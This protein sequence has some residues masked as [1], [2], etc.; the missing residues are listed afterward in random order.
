MMKKIFAF[1]L[2]LSINASMLLVIPSFAEDAYTDTSGW[3]IT[4]ESIMGA[5]NDITK[6]IDGDINTYWHSKYY[7]EDGKVFVECSD[8][9]QITYS[10]RGRR[11]KA[12]NIAE[13]YINGAVFE[14]KDTDGYF[15][16]DVVDDKGQRANTQAYF[17]QE[18]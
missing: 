7:V 16:I 6:A 13:G 1:L 8:A 12:V 9:K 3:T 4:T 2:A 5:F 15:R 17:I 11:A 18:L 10:T 14:I